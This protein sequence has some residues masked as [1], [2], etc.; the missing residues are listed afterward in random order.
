MPPAT[1]PPP[2]LIIGA[3][4]A[5][6]TAGW[7][8]LQAGLRPAL[9]DPCPG[10]KA[11][12]LQPAP[13][14]I[15]ERG[16]H[17]FTGRARAL[18]DLCRELDLAPIPLG[19]RA[20]R[21]Y[22][23]RGDQLLPAGPGLIP[24]RHRLPLLWHLLRADP[25]PA[26]PAESVAAW[27]RRRLGPAGAALAAGPAAAMLKGIWA[28]SPE[29]IE[30]RTGFPALHAA[31]QGRRLLPALRGIGGTGGAFT[32]PGGMGA[33]TD[34]LR[35]RLGDS[36]LPLR[37]A[38]VSADPGPGPRFTVRTADADGAPGPTL[39]ADRLLI[40]ADPADAARLLQDA[41][42]GAARALAALPAA[43]LLVA[44]WLSPDAAFPP[45]FGFLSEDAP[46]QPPDP[47]LGTIFLSDL[48]PDRAPPGMRAFT[49]MI[50]GTARPDALGWDD[51]QARA[52]L[53][54]AHARLT[55]RPCALAALHLVR[56]PRAVSLPAPGHPG[57]VRAI[58][59][60]LPPGLHLAGAWRAAGAMPCAL[61]SG[62]EAARRLSAP[63]AA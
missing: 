23:R 16:P 29:E 41:C 15:I 51:Q 49:S 12:T 13:G 17:T 61:A 59:A 50:G 58:D 6:L 2:P 10:G 46:G 25:G 31:S 28:A 38:A 7:R 44:H 36:L 37:A 35:A 14:W 42:P 11:R 24:W 33:L 62:E 21:R 57:R 22:L 52:H 60:G 48:L 32:L 30:F 20:R 3:G 1:T 4:L 18:H 47:L 9:L 55:G 56:H 27:L 40:A 45:G 34:A 53:L 26:D 8:L 39:R 54:D 19:A 5:G 63:G 43:P